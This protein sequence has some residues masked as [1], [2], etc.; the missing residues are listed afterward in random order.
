MIFN[1][2]SVLACVFVLTATIFVQAQ[3]HVCYVRYSYADTQ[4]K[5]RSNFFGLGEFRISFADETVTKSFYHDES[6]VT[7][8][9]G[10]TYPSRTVGNENAGLILAIAFSGKPEN[11][12]DEV[13]RAE[14]QASGRNPLKS[15]LLLSKS[16]ETENRIWKFYLSCVPEKKQRK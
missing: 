9:V 7:V 5:A 3:S 8:N 16:V 14:A 10:V 11:I 4:L 12:F 13:G 2:K 15:S 6:K 1:R